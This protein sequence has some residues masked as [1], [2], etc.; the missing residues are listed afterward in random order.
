[1]SGI[2]LFLL[3]TSPLIFQILFGR[4]AIAESIKLNLS[5]VCLISFISQIVFF[6]LSSEILSSNL[7]GRSHCGM[8]FV[9]LLVLNFFFIIVLFITMLIQF[10]IKRSYD[11]EEQE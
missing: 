9:G 8:P 1:M 6:F 10:F 4:K 2:I 3:V 5:Q 11:S 7:E